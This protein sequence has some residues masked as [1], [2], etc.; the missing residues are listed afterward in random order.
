MPVYPHLPLTPAMTESAL[1]ADPSSSATLTVGR[2]RQLSQLERGLARLVEELPI[3][4]LVFG[5]SG[6]LRHVNAWARRFEAELDDV[7]RRLV[8]DATQ[9]LASEARRAYAALR[10]QTTQQRRLVL[11]SHVLDLRSAVVSS[12]ATAAAV[13]VMIA[14]AQAASLVPTASVVRLTEREL[15]VANLLRQGATNAA[16][17]DRLGISP[18]T[19]ERHVERILR[20]L[21]IRSRHL[22]GLALDT[23]GEPLPR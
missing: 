16:I 11:Q 17:A 15:D 21:R 10:L 3:P 18:R 22:V 8:D 1:R 4:A 13:V 19:V 2:A 5:T 7:Q 23:A 20:K 9:E 12:T 14:P 6:A